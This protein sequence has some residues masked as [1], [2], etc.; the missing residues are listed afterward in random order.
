MCLKASPQVHRRLYPGCWTVLGCPICPS[1]CIVASASS[2]HTHAPPPPVPCKD[3]CTL[4]FQ[5]DPLWNAFTSDPRRPAQAHPV[6][7]AGHPGHHRLGPNP[8][9][10]PCQLCS[11][12]SA[13]T[14]HR[15]DFGAVSMCTWM[16]ALPSPAP[17]P[18][19]VLSLE[20]PD[21]GSK[22]KS[23]LQFCFAHLHA[24]PGT[25][26]CTHKDRNVHMP[27]YTCARHPHSQALIRTCMQTCVHITHLAV[28]CTNAHARMQHP[29]AH[30][31][32]LMHTQSCTRANKCITHCPLAHMHLVPHMFTLTGT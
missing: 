12:R 17:L 6:F 24:R 7:V 11:P 10:S 29:P 20:L 32:L 3:P 30:M 18:P 19:S 22:S 9:L 4:R 31:H 8:T 15:A 21:S 5:E 16:L 27:A 2:R 14:A 1:A 26:A 13:R 23:S 28:H 25:Q